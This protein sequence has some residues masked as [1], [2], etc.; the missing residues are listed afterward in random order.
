[1]ATLTIEPTGDTVEVA[2]G[3]TLLDACLRA[4]LYLPHACGHGLC[5]TCKV[6]VL[7]GEVAHGAASSF[8]LMDFERDEGATLACVATIQGD[9][10]IEADIDDDPDA[11][12]IAVADHVG[13]VSKLEMLTPDILGVWLD[14]AGEGVFFQAGQYVNLSID[15]IEG[16]RAF[17]IASSPAEANIVELHV[18]LVPGGK[19]TT[20]LHEHLK[21]GD[22]IRFAGP[23]GRFF[24]RRSANKPLIF[25]AG[26]SGLSSPKSMILE[27][28]GQ[29]YDQPITLIH[30]ARRPHDLHYAD[31]FRKLA[32]ENPT[33]RYVPVLS[34]AEPEDA[35]EGET[36]YVHEA[37]ERLFAGRFT[38][39]QA[40]LCGPPPMI[41]AGIGALMKGRLFERDIFVEK[42]VTAADAE[43]S[44]R[45]P[46]FKKL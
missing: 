41:E 27:L 24:V 34:Q 1:M 25:L 22:Q 20:H 13:T 30:G 29:G 37:A 15:G 10:T 23:F 33:F 12:R 31:F 8:A 9:V 18:R 6:S 14:V 26:G 42:F 32:E 39:H 38:G 16:T 46:F 21:V 5:G 7:E 45:S 17:S 43:K 3:Q 4:G 44:V 35:W 19:A 36:G 40:Y 28:I 2:E 11:R